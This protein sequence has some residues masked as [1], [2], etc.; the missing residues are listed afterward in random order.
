MSTQEKARKFFHA[1]NHET[2]IR[3]LLEKVFDVEDRLA[4]IENELHKL[5]CKDE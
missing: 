5:K 1:N 4:K 3:I 2:C